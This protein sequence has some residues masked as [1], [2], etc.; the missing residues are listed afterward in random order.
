MT[1]EGSGDGC[2]KGTS[3]EQR[4]YVGRCGYRA[5]HK[6]SNSGKSNHCSGDQHHDHRA[7]FNIVAR[8]ERV[9]PMIENL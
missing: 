6:S 1:D 3:G 7:V 9:V 4:Q 2:G 5:E 8:L